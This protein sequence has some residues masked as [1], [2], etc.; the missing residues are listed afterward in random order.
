MYS[1]CSLTERSILG[2]DWGL[3]KPVSVCLSANQ[4]IFYHPEEVIRAWGFP[5]PKWGPSTLITKK[6]NYIMHPCYRELRTGRSW[7]GRYQPSNLIFYYGPNNIWRHIA[8]TNFN[9]KPLLATV[10]T[11]NVCSSQRGHPIC[12][13]D[14]RY[15]LCIYILSYTRFNSMICLLMQQMGDIFWLYESLMASR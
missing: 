10:V 13:A 6:R 9:E 8:L 3:E 7:E 11:M 14:N 15:M 12:H 4:N 1:E 2:T 5:N